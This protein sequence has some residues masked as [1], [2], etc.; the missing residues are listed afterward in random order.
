M[1]KI[2]L[3]IK[4][5]LKGYWRL[6]GELNYSP[7]ARRPWQP[8]KNRGN[9]LNTFKKYFKFYYGPWSKDVELTY[10]LS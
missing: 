2:A 10:S 4:F 8:T 7:N 3:K 6:L 1:C 9:K 5:K